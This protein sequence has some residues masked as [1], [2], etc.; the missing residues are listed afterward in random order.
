MGVF[1]ASFARLLRVFIFHRILDQMLYSYAISSIGFSGCFAR[2]INWSDSPFVVG[3][4]HVRP[5]YSDALFWVN[6]CYFSGRRARICAS[7][8]STRS[9][10]AFLKYGNKTDRPPVPV[11][12]T[13]CCAYVSGGFNER[14]TRSSCTTF[15][16][17]P[18]PNKMVAALCRKS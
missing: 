14:S 7:M 6:W 18:I 9:S 4:W 10:A 1:C 11:Y 13:L 16:G 17:T 8:F 15:I 3:F 12:T 5:I 2:K